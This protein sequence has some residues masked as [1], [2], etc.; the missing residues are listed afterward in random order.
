MLLHMLIELGKEMSEKD[1]HYKCITLE[2]STEQ[3][4]DFYESHGFKK[5]VGRQMVIVSTYSFY[6]RNRI[7]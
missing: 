5:L 1:N 3:A 4:C 2:A 7:L 6:N